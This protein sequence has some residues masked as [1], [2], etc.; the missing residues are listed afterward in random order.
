MAAILTM[1]S[2]PTTV[3]RPVPA[4]PPPSNSERPAARP[5]R[6]KARELVERLLVEGHVRFTHADDEEIA[7]WRRVV[8]YAKRHGMERCSPT[9]TFSTTV[10]AVREGRSICD[11]IVTFVRF[12]LSTDIGAILTLLATVLAGLP[13][14]CPR[15]SCS[16]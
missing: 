6:A 8:N 9:T 16:G 1:R 3:S 7:E 12:Q 13:A 15:S 4:E 14:P 10:R 5:R 2:L 11:T